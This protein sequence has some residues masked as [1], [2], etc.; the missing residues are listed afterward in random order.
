MHV[1]VLLQDDVAGSP[2]VTASA[3]A[4][5]NRL[6][7]FEQAPSSSRA[8]D[9]L[10]LRLIA[11]LQ[12][13]FTLHID[14]RTTPVTKLTIIVEDIAYVGVFVATAFDSDKQEVAQGECCCFY[15]ALENCLANSALALGV[16]RLEVDVDMLDQNGD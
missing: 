6:I 10:E 2:L 8:I 12:R 11:I 1:A 3:F 7:A 16:K 9:I 13:P 15:G 5:D 14:D 4:S